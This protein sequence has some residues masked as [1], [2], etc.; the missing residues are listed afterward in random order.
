M[1]QRICL[2][3]REL[4]NHRGSRRHDPPLGLL[5]PVSEEV[6]QGSK[7]DLC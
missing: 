1:G 2:E 6:V 7:A 4:H 5:A 3:V